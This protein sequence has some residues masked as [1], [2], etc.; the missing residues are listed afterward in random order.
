[1][2][3]V[4]LGASLRRQPVARIRLLSLRVNSVT[5]FLCPPGGRGPRGA[6][7]VAGDNSLSQ[8]AGSATATPLQSPQRRRITA[9]T[10]GRGS[11]E[12]LLAS[13]W[14]SFVRALIWPRR[15]PHSRDF[16]ATNSTERQR[17]EVCST[18]RYRKSGILRRCLFAIC[19]PLVSIFVGFQ[20]PLGTSRQENSVLMRFA[21]YR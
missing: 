20:P 19:S 13:L 4:T 11:H 1:V 8:R 3:L 10:P 14:T 6:T 9:G 7:M 15:A 2:A 17:Q 16:P 21:L 12:Q 18:G 5:L